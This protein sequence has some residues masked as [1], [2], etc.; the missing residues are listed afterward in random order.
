MLEIITAFMMLVAGAALVHEMTKD[1]QQQSD[2]VTSHIKKIDEV[3]SLGLTSLYLALKKDD[4]GFFLK[5]KHQL[6]ESNLYSMEK[7]LIHLTYQADEKTLGSD[8]QDSL[9]TISNCKYRI[10]KIRN[11]IKELDEYF[12]MKGEINGK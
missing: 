2:D 6:G 10:Q 8:Y 5:V 3:T 1:K 7:N 12:Q 9:A 4:Y 11:R